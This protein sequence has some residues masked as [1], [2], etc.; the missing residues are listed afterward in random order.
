MVRTARR[1]LKSCDMRCTTGDFRKASWR[2]LIS[3]RSVPL[4]D[5]S[6]GRRLACSKRLIHSLL[7]MTLQVL[8]FGHET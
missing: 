4:Y 2:I 1:A 3:G 7:T 6:I 8:T 5:N